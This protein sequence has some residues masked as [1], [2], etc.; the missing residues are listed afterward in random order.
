MPPLPVVSGDDTR[1]ALER[2]GWTFE[3]QRGSHLVMSRRGRSSIA[4]PRARELPRGTLRGIIRD[5]GLTVEEF[6]D[7][8]AR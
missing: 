8:L 2:A 6:A 1:A 7:L 3:R 5:A 4:I